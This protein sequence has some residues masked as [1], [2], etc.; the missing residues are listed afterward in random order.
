MGYPTAYPMGPMY[1]RG[2][3][4]GMSHG[5]HWPMGSPIDTTPEYHGLLVDITESMGDPMGPCITWDIPCDMP[6]MCHGYLD[7]MVL[8]VYTMMSIGYPMGYA[9]VYIVP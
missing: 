4:H 3:S 1:P 7:T 9:M 8:R 2:T 5:I 6:K